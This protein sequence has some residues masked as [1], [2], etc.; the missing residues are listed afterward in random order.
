MP[1]WRLLYFRR[2]VHVPLLVEILQQRVPLCLID[3]FILRS[4]PAYS[5]LL[6]QPAELHPCYLRVAWPRSRPIRLQVRHGL[7]N[8]GVGI[9]LRRTCPSMHDERKNRGAAGALAAAARQ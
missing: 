8:G 4:V 9:S 2:S 7:C 5:L 3:L 6:P 1:V